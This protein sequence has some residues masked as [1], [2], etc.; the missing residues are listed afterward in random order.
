[1]RFDLFMIIIMIMQA[2]TGQPGLPGDPRSQSRALCECQR[3]DI[4]TNIMI[5]I[6]LQDHLALR[7]VYESFKRESRRTSP[8]RD[9]S[10][11]DIV[12]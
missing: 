8:G 7:R 3:R 11:R 9:R 12:S 4:M 6:A 5:M 2:S 10:R 1:M